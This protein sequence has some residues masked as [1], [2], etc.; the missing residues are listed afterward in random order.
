M[1]SSDFDQLLAEYRAAVDRLVDEVHKEE[2][3][4]N[5]DHSI[6]EMERWDDEEFKVEDA[7]KVARKARAAYKDALRQKN[8]GF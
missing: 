7:A 6:V 3:L 2:A 4:A 8:Y 1:E 5:A